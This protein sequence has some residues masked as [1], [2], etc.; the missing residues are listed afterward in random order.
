MV[1]DNPRS[2]ALS[3]WTASGAKLLLRWLERTSS[4]PLKGA[5]PRGLPHHCISCGSLLKD[6][7]A[8]YLQ[9]PSQWHL[10][11]TVIYWISSK[12]Q[13]QGLSW[14]SSSWVVNV[15]HLRRIEEQSVTG[16]SAETEWE[17]GRDSEMQ[18]HRRETEGVFSS[19]DCVSLVI[20]LQPSRSRLDLL[21]VHYPLP[22]LNGGSA[23]NTHT[24]PSFLGSFLFPLSGLTWEP[25]SE[26]DLFLYP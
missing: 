5:Y 20:M 12:E 22:L 6:L 26:R 13:T 17:R 21:L 25:G 3:P 23:K 4:S 9:F 15:C 14:W 1:L 16:T 18:R 7:Q 2:P 24:W 10:Q 11:L 8:K 19:H